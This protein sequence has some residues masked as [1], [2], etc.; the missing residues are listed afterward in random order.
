MA[1]MA[2]GTAEQ[3]EMAQDALNRFWWPSIM[4]FGPQDSDSLLQFANP[5]NLSF[6]SS[7]RFSI[8]VDRKSLKYFLF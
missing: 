1:E 7:F 6:F 5:D 4:M 8:I 3:K 2:K